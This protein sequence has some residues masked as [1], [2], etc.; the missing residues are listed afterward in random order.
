MVDA[1]GIKNY[2]YNNQ[3][4]DDAD[5]APYSYLAVMG[6]TF[7]ERCYVLD[8]LTPIMN[9]NVVGFLISFII[10]TVFVSHFRKEQSY[11]V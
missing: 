11:P 3:L 2:A 7:I 8:N 1:I 5:V 6:H 10:W 4:K 9:I